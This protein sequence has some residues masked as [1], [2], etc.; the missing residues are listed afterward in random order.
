MSRAMSAE[1]SL[2]HGLSQIRHASL[3]AE[4]LEMMGKQAA[5]M[6]LD[7]GLSLNEGVA[8]L[9]GDHDDISH[10]QVKRIC[11]FANTAV[12]L[13]KH[14]QSKTAG[15]GSS[16]PQFEL[17]DPNRVIQDLGDGARP[18]VVTKTD[19]EYSRLPAKS[20]KTA[21]VKNSLEAGLEEMFKVSSSESDYSPETVV[22]N[23]MGAKSTLVALKENLSASGEQIDLSLKQA[24]ADYYDTV[25]RHLLNEGDFADVMAAARS[26]TSDNDKIAQALRPVIE[27]LMVE[28]VAS[29]EKLKK[30]VR[31]L[32][33]VAHRIVNSN[34]PLSSL[35]G[36]I[37]SLSDEVEKVATSLLQVDRD[38]ERV[39]AYIRE[40]Y[41]ARTAR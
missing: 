15:A 35:F 30:S 4:S 7:E 31:G 24:G 12:Y 26:V 28:K 27:R 20:E 1:E 36:T 11:E 29:P 22:S 33:K 3:S 37:V 6:F 34:H 9:A 40:N 8:K 17:A 38:L 2:L 39:N 5:N 16:Y 19:I 41:L 13:A 18:T 14:D 32:D 25:K 10:E 21:S 23:V